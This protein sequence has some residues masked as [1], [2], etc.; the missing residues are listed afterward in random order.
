MRF[1]L[2]FTAFSDLSAPY[3]RKNFEKIRIFILQPP[4]ANVTKSALYI[5]EALDAR[6]SWLGQPVC[7]S[8]R[9]LG[10]I[11]ALVRSPGWEAPGR[12][13][14]GPGQVCYRGSEQGYVAAR[15]EVL[16]ARR[17]CRVR[18]VQDDARTAIGKKWNDGW[19]GDNERTK[20]K[21]SGRPS[22]RPAD[23]FV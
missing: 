20:S 2:L 3:R 18:L 5:W 12:P 7:I 23:A 9:G 4:T 1:F 8:P 10:S 21:R 19:V 15:L 13:A 16:L 17:S 11:L 14:R 6:A 22:R